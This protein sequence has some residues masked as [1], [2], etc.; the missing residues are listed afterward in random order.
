[1]NPPLPQIRQT[2]AG[3]SASIASFLARSLGQS[4]GR[5]M[6]RNRLLSLAVF[7]VALT[8]FGC[9]ENVHVV[10][11]VAFPDGTPLTSGDVLFTDGFH[12]GKSELNENGE[13]S[14][15]SFRRNDGIPKGVYNVYITGAIAFEVS[16]LDRDKNE[17]YRLNKVKLLIDM[18]HTNPDMSGWEFDVQKDTRID[19]I[20]YPPGQ[21]PE[22]KR[23]NAAK[24]AS[25]A[26]Y[27]KKVDGASSL[28][29]S[30]DV[31]K[32]TVKRRRVNPHLL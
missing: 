30:D 7:A 22:E 11:K 1:M 15:H 3:T 21:V 28:P 12:L 16:D 32:K 19:L 5:R 17:A 2:N 8:A 23:T 4:Y 14:L 18:Q 20:V 31:S 13:Y 29:E 6:F 26:E 27:R 9:G 24:Y 10:G 25:D